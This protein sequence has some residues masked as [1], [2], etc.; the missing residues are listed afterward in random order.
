MFEIKIITCHFV[1]NYGAVLQ[2]YALSHAL[3]KLFPNAN[4]EII[5]YRPEYLAVHH[6]V[7]HI[8]SEKYRR[9]W[10][11][12]L[13]YIFRTFPFR[14]YTSF[15]FSRFIKR[16]LKLTSK[17]YTDFE[18]L[19]VGNIKADIFICGSDQIW[20]YRSD[21]GKDPAFFLKFVEK[22]KKIS[23]APSIAVSDIN[24]L[25]EKMLSF[26]LK[27]FKDISIREQSGVQ[28][29]KKV[30]YENVSRV[31]DPVFL[32]EKQDWNKLLAKFTVKKKYVLIYKITRNIEL[33]DFA[34]DLVREREWDIIE[35]GFSAKCDGKVDKYL[36]GVS[37]ELFLAYVLGAEYIITDSFHGTAFSVLFEK[38]FVVF[39]R[40]DL[41]S[42]IE[43]LLKI[44]GLESRYFDKKRTANSYYEEEIEYQNVAM[45]LN[46]EREFSVNYLLG[47]ILDDNNK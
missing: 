11:I 39:D 6:R 23:Y 45:K 32:L 18:E 15:N 20:N 28:I 2:A 34:Y 40:G 22:G 3:E 43:T 29:L 14:M 17:R 13:L 36:C 41:N 38:P 35:I 46:K 47:S 1:H 27:G 8:G 12:K 30:G 26:M 42:R 16:N 21:N 44:T 9:N 4:I 7:F 37:P 31:L 10:L 5:D 33:Y 19:K 25:E 24:L